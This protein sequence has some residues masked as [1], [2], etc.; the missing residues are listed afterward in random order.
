MTDVY[1]LTRKKMITYTYVCMLYVYYKFFFRVEEQG[2]IFQSSEYCLVVECR[3]IW[4][5]IKQQQSLTNGH[6]SPT[7]ANLFHPFHGSIYMQMA[8][9]T[10]FGIKTFLKKLTMNLSSKHT[11]MISI[12]YYW[13]FLKHPDS[14]YLLT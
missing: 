5:L 12:L 6:E 10:F 1:N 8:Q 9:W 11:F 4:Y 13:P 14:L 3:Y 7:Y 2:S